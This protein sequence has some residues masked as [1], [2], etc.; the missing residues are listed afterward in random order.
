MVVSRRV[1]S[2]EVLALN[3]GEGTFFAPRAEA[4]P[5]SDEQAWQLADGFDPTAVT[6]D[7]QWLLRFRA[8]AIRFDDGRVILFDAGIGPVGSP[9]ASW[10]PV[11]GRLP[12]ELAAAGIDPGEIGQVVISHLHTDHIG[13]WFGG[14][15]PNA[16]VLVQRA[17]LDWVAPERREQMPQERL[18]LLDGDSRLAGPARIVATPGHTP[19]HQSC[20][21]EDGDDVL[22]ITGDLLV[23]AL[24]LVLPE[25]PYALEMDSELARDSRVSLLAQAKT[26]ATPHLTEPFVDLSRVAV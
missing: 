24:Q 16:A 6:A 5:A 4:F 2:V 23:H 14:L 1:G 19:G 21:I 20:L 10:A 3:D 12:Q 18:V 13:W 7:G 11:P 8:F 9:A 22:A 26:I 25:S 17:E 15:F